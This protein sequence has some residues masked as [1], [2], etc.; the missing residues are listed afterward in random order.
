[1]KTRIFKTI[2]LLFIVLLSINAYAN[3]YDFNFVKN[4]V[5]LSNITSNITQ[6][7]NFV[8]LELNGTMKIEGLN[9][10][11]VDNTLGINNSDI[12]TSGFASYYLSSNEILNSIRLYSNY[13]DKGH[14]E[15][16]LIIDGNDLA[17][18][19]GDYSKQLGK[20]IFTRATYSNI[21]YGTNFNGTTYTN[22]NINFPFELNNNGLGLSETSLSFKNMTYNKTTDGFIKDAICNFT[23]KI[24]VNKNYVSYY[25][26]LYILVNPIDKVYFC[27]NKIDIS[28][29]LIC[30]HNFI[31]DYTTI[32]KN[33]HTEY[34]TKCKWNKIVAHKYTHIYDGITNNQCACGYNEFANI[35]IIDS[36]DN[37][38]YND[39]LNTFS[40]INVN[41]KNLIDSK[42]EI[43]YIDEFEYAPKDYD[44]SN[45]EYSWE[46]I[47]RVSRLP[48]NINNLSLKF[49]VYTKEK[50]TSNSTQTNNST[51]SSG[52][53]GSSGGGITIT[54]TPKSTP[55]VKIDNKLFGATPTYQKSSSLYR[56]SS[57]STGASSCSSSQYYNQGLTLENTNVKFTQNDTE[58]IFNITADSS[59]K[60][61]GNT[62]TNK[63]LCKVNSYDIPQPALYKSENF[64]DKMEISE[65]GKIGFADYSNDYINS[66]SSLKIKNQEIG[67]YYSEDYIKG[68]FTHNNINTTKRD[69]GDKFYIS[70]DARI[71]ALS[72]T[73]NYQNATKYPHNLENNGE[74]VRFISNSS[75]KTYT[76]YLFDVDGN[77]N[78]EYIDTVNTNFSVKI[79]VNKSNIDDYRY[80]CFLCSEI[81]HISTSAS[82]GSYSSNGYSLST[83]TIDLKNYINC[84]HDW[85]YS[86][87]ADDSTNHKKICSKCE[88]ETTEAHNCQYEYDGII[89][90]LC[91]CGFKKQVKIHST[92]NSDTMTTN[93]Q[94]INAGAT[95][96]K[97]D[98]PTKTGYTFKNFKKYTKTINGTYSKTAT[99]LTNTYIAEVNA[100][101]N[102]AGDLS[103]IYE[104]QYDP[105][106]YNVVFSATNNKRLPVSLAGISNINN[107][108]YDTEYDTPQVSYTGYKF[109]GWTKTSGSSSVDIQ[110]TDKILNLTATSGA[111]IT[112]FPVFENI[113]YKFTFSKDN[114]LNLAI[115]TEIPELECEYGSTY[116]LPN[117]IEI[118]GY[119]FNGWTFTKD[120]ST[121]NLGKNAE[122]KNYTTIADK[123]YIL[124]PVYTPIRYTFKFSDINNLGLTFTSTPSELNCD[125]GTIYYLPDNIEKNGYKFLGWTLTEGSTITNFGEKAE[126][127]NYTTENNK[128]FTLYPVYDYRVYTIKCDFRQ[129]K[130]TK[131]ELLE[132]VV[133]KTK[134][135]FPKLSIL[136]LSAHGYGWF[137]NGIKVESSLELD[138]Y[139]TKDNQIITIEYRLDDGASAYLEDVKDFK[140]SIVCEYS[141]NNEILSQKLE[142]VKIGVL[143]E[144]PKVKV[145]P[146]TAKVYGWFYEDNKVSSSLDIDQYITKNNESITIKYK[147][148]DGANVYLDDSNL[149][150][151]YNI[152][153]E[154]LNDNNVLSKDINSVKIGTKTEFPKIKV[155][156]T[157]AKV[158]GWFYN[159]IQISNSLDLDKYIKT[160]NEIITIRYKVED[161]ARCYSDDVLTYKIKYLYNNGLLA[162]IS[163]IELGTNQELYKLTEYDLN[164]MVRERYWYYKDKGNWV[165]NTY[166]VEK[167][168]RF[169][170]ETITLLYYIG[171]YQNAGLY[172]NP[173]RSSEGGGGGPSNRRIFTEDTGLSPLT[174]EIDNQIILEYAYVP[175]KY[176]NKEIT[177][178]EL[179]QIIEDIEVQGHTLTERE[180]FYLKYGV[181]VNDESYEKNYHDIKTVPAT[182]FN[183]FLM[184]IL[185]YKIWVITA[186]ILGIALLGV[187]LYYEHKKETKK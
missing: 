165:N 152:K 37:S 23:L 89:N 146:I 38:L 40:N 114:N 179:E 104:A 126:I 174:E 127:F 71:D 95:F 158:Y 150:L 59:F 88:W 24:K 33:G 84:D 21:N 17:F 79:A 48:D 22:E 90:D 81:G 183:I 167:F 102:N 13:S 87:V 185:K 139:I 122:I 15:S 116:N 5:G 46:Y 130:A 32:N 18:V 164:D 6:N 182:K 39:K 148:E 153:C 118:T 54:E 171:Y 35:K 133:V 106:K 142:N 61:K 30:N 56:E 110:A 184:T 60:F 143:T 166:D 157:T 50:K 92:I 100:M 178:E 26:N 105:I 68:D 1:M 172:H 161:G 103:F 97:Y 52:S 159:D 140:Y 43:D 109:M 136:P 124:Y 41:L 96:T 186:L 120:S 175:Q 57:S 53:S 138:D 154:Y 36:N 78:K 169:N 125:Y 66:S 134:R 34:C 99:P 69:N 131:S 44:Y 11:K 47:G 29:Y 74:G 101:D 19:K 12:N 162:T 75:N 144:L 147:T 108:E 49:K 91:T 129:E 121:I 163:T 117:H 4:N 149:E 94:T 135:E 155:L 2:T 27:S 113:K 64:G 98:N 123:E 80:I 14:L 58:Y 8:N 77:G 42:Y 65:S 170:N 62:L 67:Y 177:D 145:L 168:V 20:D 137:Y 70:N 51:G 173:G 72:N 111:T 107:A 86:Q 181:W 93:T 16:K 9:A 83:N 156:P 10:F 112:L 82:T 73:Y 85:T 132:N 187:Y 151:T 28:S 160:N 63:D 128:I 3:T 119:I 115:D 45:S 31:V 7:E 76:T 25:N 55:K 141:N 180:K 176:Q